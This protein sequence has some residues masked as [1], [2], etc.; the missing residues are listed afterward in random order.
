MDDDAP[1]SEAESLRAEIA[2]LR[3]ELEATRRRAL[4]M[5][6]LV[7][8]TTHH[9]EECKRRR[10]MAEVVLRRIEW[11]GYGKCLFCGVGEPGPHALSCELGEAL[12]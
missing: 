4:R 11:A 6:H 3:A 12:E 9:A 5:A 1:K 10:H 2:V 7:T 8:V